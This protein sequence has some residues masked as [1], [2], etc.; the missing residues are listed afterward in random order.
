[1][2]T[3][4]QYV[5]CMQQR[6]PEKEQPTLVTMATHLPRG[7]HSS[8]GFLR[9]RSLFAD[10]TQTLSPGSLTR[11]ACRR[12]R[13]LASSS[14]LHLS[15]S[16]SCLSFLSPLSSCAVRRRCRCRCVCNYLRVHKS[17]LS[18]QEGSVALFVVTSNCKVSIGGGA[19]WVGPVLVTL[20]LWTWTKH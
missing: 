4:S 9:L 1:M 7:P 16:L 13:P 19:V 5:A 6:E 15:P 11:S 3:G 10:W 20:N 17:H 8:S 14:Q 18:D 2:V 12:T